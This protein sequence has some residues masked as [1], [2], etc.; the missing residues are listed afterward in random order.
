MKDNPKMKKNLNLLTLIV[1]TTSLILS[2]CQNQ[3]VSIEF[4]QEMN[5]GTRLPKIKIDLLPENVII[6]QKLPNTV[7]DELLLTAWVYLYNQ[8]E[9][10]QMWDGSTLTG[11]QLAQFIIDYKIEVKWGLEEICHNNSCTPRPV[12]QTN[13]C[14]EDY[15]EIG[16]YPIYIA[17]RYQDTQVEDLPFLAGSLA[18][19]TYHHTE[20]HGKV[21]ST[22]FEEY[23]AFFVGKQIS[24]D[25]SL[26][27]KGYQPLNPSCLKLWLV[28]NNRTGYELEMYPNSILDLVD[29]D[30]P[31]CSLSAQ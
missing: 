28:Q 17:L 22:L 21:S 4:I 11:R 16:D 23:W 9:P 27:F 8:N 15:K 3:P 26:D 6:P 13:Q 31:N 5:A 19:E 1:I 7:R 24:Q 12:C 10:F 30:L 2:A 18:H 29:N 25:K 20:P 14:L